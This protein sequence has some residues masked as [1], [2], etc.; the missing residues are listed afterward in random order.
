M[1]ELQIH[2]YLRI[3]M[4]FLMRA[5]MVEKYEVV[6]LRK[7]VIYDDPFFEMLKVGYIHDEEELFVILKDSEKFWYANEFFDITGVKNFY[8]GDLK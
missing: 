4:N 6:L 7:C 3:L 1:Q 8:C 5:K 2:V